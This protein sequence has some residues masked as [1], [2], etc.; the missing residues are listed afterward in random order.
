MKRYY[1]SALVSFRSR[2][3][4]HY[5]WNQLDGNLS[6]T[7]SD[8]LCGASNEVLYDFGEFLGKTVFLGYKIPF[9]KSF[10]DYVE[11]SDFINGKRPLFLK[12]SRNL[13]KSVNGKY[14]NIEDSVKR[15]FDS[16]L[17]GEYDIRDAYFSWCIKPTYCRLGSCYTMFKTVGISPV[18]DNPNVPEYVFDFVVYHECLHL[19]QGIKWGQRVHDA[20]FHKW[21][22]E[23][24]YYKEAHD[25]FPGLKD[26][27]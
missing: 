21:E 14:R 1:S 23:Y 7:V 12:R 18:L 24:P 27:V 26:M 15:L 5:S 17:I 6:A 16:G 2:K 4:F 9:P 11:D 8:Y 22:K 10:T 19:R 20:E 3:D 25:F 13:S